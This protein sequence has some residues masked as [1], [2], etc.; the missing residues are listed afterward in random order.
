MKKIYSR[1]VLAIHGSATERT[2]GRPN[3]DWNDIFGGYFFFW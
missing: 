2:E 3:G 1:P